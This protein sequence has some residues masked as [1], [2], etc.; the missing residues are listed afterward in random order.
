MQ[1]DPRFF[2]PKP[3]GGWEWRRHALV[4][5]SLHGC[6]HSRRFASLASAKMEE[7]TDLTPPCGTSLSL[8][9]HI[10]VFVNQLQ[11]RFVK[12]KK[13][14]RKSSSAAKCDVVVSTMHP[15]READLVRLLILCR[16]YKW[17][18]KLPDLNKLGS[19]EKRVLSFLDHVIPEINEQGWSEVTHSRLRRHFLEGEPRAVLALLRQAYAWDPQVSRSDLHLT[20]PVTDRVADWGFDDSAVGLAEAAGDYN[21][22]D[23]AEAPFIRFGVK[24]LTRVCLALAKEIVNRRN[25][26]IRSSRE[27]VNICYVFREVV[28]D[29]Y[30]CCRSY[31][32]G[33]PFDDDAKNALGGYVCKL[34]GKTCYIDENLFRVGCVLWAPDHTQDPQAFI[35]R[36]LSEPLLIREAGGPVGRT[37]ACLD[38]ANM[39]LMQMVKDDYVD[40]DPMRFPAYLTHRREEFDIVDHALAVGRHHTVFKSALSCLGKI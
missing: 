15:I 16:R 21:Q 8:R 9:Q 6:R 20:F 10:G 26:L 30:A 17:D 13:K 40:P 4:S 29:R 23:L 19:V 1:V 33:T 7:T 18:N 35:R 37:V 2:R 39:I 36:I 32:E 11:K 22:L 28:A 5:L 25:A 38:T 3:T 12:M 31:L 34:S 24:D 14:I 27:P